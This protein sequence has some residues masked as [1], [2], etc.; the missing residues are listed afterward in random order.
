MQNNTVFI[1]TFDIRCLF[2]RPVYDYIKFLKIIYL[3]RKKLSEILYKIIDVGL[4][5]PDENKDRKSVV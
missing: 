2:I 3:L 5:K 1:G 4:V